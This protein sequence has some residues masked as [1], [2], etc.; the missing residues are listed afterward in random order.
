MRR[1]RSRVL[2]QFTEEEIIQ[3]RI[4]Q[5]KLGIIKGFEYPAIKYIH[6]LNLSRQIKGVKY[7]F[8]Q[9]GTLRISKVTT[10]IDIQNALREV[11]KVFFNREEDHFIDRM[12]IR[13]KLELKK[14]ANLQ[15]LL[16]KLKF[17]SV[18][19][20]LTNNEL[21]AKVDNNCAIRIR[22]DG[23]VLITQHKSYKSILTAAM[24]IVRI[25]K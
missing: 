20:C 18:E 6:S 19:C 12:T 1:K 2:V 10:F 9:N 21:F 24:N 23:S 17:Y 15:S 7:T 3:R 11:Q 8:K 22:K 5:I 13:I 4:Y 16:N 25:M 14:A